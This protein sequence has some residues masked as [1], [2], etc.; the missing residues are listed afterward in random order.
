MG[1]LHTEWNGIIFRSISIY[2]VPWP[3][4]FYLRFS[5][6]RFALIATIRGKTWNNSF[7]VPPRDQKRNLFVNVWPPLRKT[8]LKYYNCAKISIQTRRSPS[9]FPFF[10]LSFF[11][12]FFLAKRPL[13]KV[14]RK[15]NWTRSILKS[16]RYSSRDRRLRIFLEN[17]SIT[18]QDGGF[19]TRNRNRNRNRTEDRN[20]DASW[21][22][23]EGMNYAIFR[24]Y[25]ALIIRETSPF[26]PVIYMA[27]FICIIT[28]LAAVSAIETSVVE[29]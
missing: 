15:I 27:H 25:V 8:I 28:T 10:F 4:L 23:N 18:R 20:G 13:K 3:T 7:T 26:R 22:G 9:S 24:G 6:I 1:Q 2:F 14:K 5:F 21:S 29:I 12:F 11:K 16:Q 17:W 19:S